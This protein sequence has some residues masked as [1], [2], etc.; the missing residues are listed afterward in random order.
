MPRDAQGFEVFIPL[1]ELRRVLAAL[2]PG[3]PDNATLRL[4]VASGYL[5]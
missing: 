3:T 1:A 2:P 5:K 4:T